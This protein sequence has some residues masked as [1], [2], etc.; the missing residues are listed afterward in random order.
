MSEI[1]PTYSLPAD[2]NPASMYLSSLSPGSLPAMEGALHKIAVLLGSTGAFSCNWAALRFRHVQAI[3]TKLLE[4]YDYKTVN[5]MMCAVRGALKAAWL[6]GQM[7]AEDYHKA[8]SVKSISGEK[9]PPGRS[10]SPGE[11]KALIDVC[12]ADNSPA[13]IRDAAIISVMYAAGLRRS[14]VV[15]LNLDD[16]SIEEG[17]VTIRG[18]KSRTDRTSYILNGGSRAIN[19]WLQIR[20]LEPGPMFYPITKTGEIQRRRM[21]S[22]AIFNMLRKRADQAEIPSFSPHDIR[23]THISDMLETGADV[24]TVAK[25]VGHKSPQ[26]TMLYDRRGEQAK[27]KAANMLHVPY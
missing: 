5:K 23:R 15:D 19:A 8:R 10:L 25:M 11:I 6:D 4:T 1:V 26:T 3:Q 12:K 27:I 17:Q 20:G 21:S 22:Q 2:R 7:T 18:S 13:G 9:L 16:Y 24:L 14:E